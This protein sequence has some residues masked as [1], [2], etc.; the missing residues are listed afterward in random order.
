MSSSPIHSRLSWQPLGQMF[1]SFLIR[2]S[3]QLAS[4]LK[5]CHPAPSTTG[6]AASSFSPWEGCPT[7]KG[8]FSSSGSF[9]TGGIARSHN[10][11]NCQLEDV[12]HNRPRSQLWQP[13]GRMSRPIPKLS[14]TQIS[15]SLMIS[16]TIGQVAISSSPWE[17]CRLCSSYMELRLLVVSSFGGSVSSTTS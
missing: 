1:S 2:S 14:S 11:S 16:Y 7:W 3:S 6:A 8:F 4:P 13:L 10:H 12:L 15:L 5:G 17:V 9:T